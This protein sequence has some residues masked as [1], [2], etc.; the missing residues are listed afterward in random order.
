MRRSANEIRILKNELAEQMNRIE[1]LIQSMDGA[2]QG[3][4]ERALENKILVL[5][6][7]HAQLL[8][9]INTYARLLLD[10]SGKY[11]QLEKANASK[12]SLA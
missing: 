2:W 6:D 7:R 11:E 9:S 10:F 4:S 1:E 8:D 3:D 5:K 12:I